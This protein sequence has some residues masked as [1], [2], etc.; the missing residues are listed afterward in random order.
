MD[1]TTTG[2]PAQGL[3]RA[4]SP[5]TLIPGRA[6]APYKAESRRDGEVPGTLERFTVWIADDPRPEPHDHP[7]PFASAILTGGYSERRFRRGADGAWAA[8]GVF[9]WRAGQTVEVPAGDAHVVFDVLPGTTTHMRI[10]PLTAGPR[11]WGHLL[12]GPAGALVW[13]QAAASPEFLAQ[14]AALNQRPA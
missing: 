10:G 1:T 5:F 2:L 11:D 8:R 7:W 6:G 4:W 14:L 13:T 12:P 9:V 3:G